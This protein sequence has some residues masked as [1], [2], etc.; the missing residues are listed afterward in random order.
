MKKKNTIK[1][2]AYNGQGGIPV[3]D[4]IFYLCLNCKSILQ[5]SPKESIA[6][7][8]RNVSIDVD[9]ARAGAKD[10]SRFMILGIE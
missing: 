4:S 10:M 5:S 9:Y 6:C 8:C 7:K 2:I 1:E 3:G